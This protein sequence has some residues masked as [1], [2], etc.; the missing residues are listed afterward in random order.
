MLT[1]S[2][3]FGQEARDELAASDV[4]YQHLIARPRSPKNHGEPC[5]DVQAGMPLTSLFSAFVP[6]LTAGKQF[7]CTAYEEW[8]RRWFFE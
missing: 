2:N 3:S 7:S 6:C 1:Q 8:T 5:Q 4:V